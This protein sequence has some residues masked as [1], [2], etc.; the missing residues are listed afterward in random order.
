M[1]R[2]ETSPSAPPSV[3]DCIEAVG[4][5]LFAVLRE[6]G[7]LMPVSAEVVFS[8]AGYDRMVR[9]L[10]AELGS[11]ERFTLADV[12]DLFGTSRRYAQA[13]LEHLDSMGITRRIGDARVLE[14]GP[15]DRQL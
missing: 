3:K 8:T 6:Q 11:L 2:F 10:R 5:E 9:T 15:A 12:R 7:M 14:P 1:R 4:A 13:L